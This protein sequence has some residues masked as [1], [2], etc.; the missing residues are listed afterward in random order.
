MALVLMVSRHVRDIHV[1]HR[2]LQWA[3]EIIALFFFINVHFC[4]FFSLCYILHLYCL[5]FVFVCN[6]SSPYLED[7]E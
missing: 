3:T 7:N 5:S 2:C 6:V 4:L 1:M